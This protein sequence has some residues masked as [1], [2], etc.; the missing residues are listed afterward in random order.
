MIYQL[1]CSLNT[2]PYDILLCHS[3]LKDITLIQSF[4]QFQRKTIRI[5]NG[6]KAAQTLHNKHMDVLYAGRETIQKHKWK[7]LTDRVHFSYSELLF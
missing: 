1:L 4:H 6:M 3:H 2:Q 5:T 7:G